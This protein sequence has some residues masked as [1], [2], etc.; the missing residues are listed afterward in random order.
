MKKVVEKASQYDRNGIEIRFLN[1]T[2]WGVVK[3]CLGN[4]KT[5]GDVV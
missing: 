3:V 5:C 2:E 4:R 1:T